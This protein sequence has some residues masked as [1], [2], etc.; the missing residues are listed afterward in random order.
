MNLTITTLDKLA[1]RLDVSKRTLRR[2]QRLPADLQD[3]A[4]RY[5]ITA[6]ANDLDPR[7]PGDL[8]WLAG[9]LGVSGRTLRR[10]QHFIVFP[11]WLQLACAAI[12]HGMPPAAAL[13]VPFTRR[14][15]FDNLRAG[16][17]IGR[18]GRGK[19]LSPRKRAKRLHIIGRNPDGSYIYK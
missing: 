12:E 7:K 6:L 3:L 17:F 18:E 16:M 8:P 4:Y 14:H 5:A 11:L 19:R 15:R 2:Q 10:W 9:V 1:H 13:P